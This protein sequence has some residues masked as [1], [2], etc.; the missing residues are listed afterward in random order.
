MGSPDG[1]REGEVELRARG[2]WWTRGAGGWG[3][4]LC[5]SRPQTRWLAGTR[6]QLSTGPSAAVSG[7]P[8]AG[9]PG[10]KQSD[11]QKTEESGSEAGQAR[12]RG[13][14]GI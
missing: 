5:H 8:A 4:T 11:A 10:R 1:G 3:R 7:S 6:T 13:G 9:V 2:A 14:R 12:R